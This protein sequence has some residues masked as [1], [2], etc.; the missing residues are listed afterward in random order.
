MS[1]LQLGLQVGSNQALTDFHLD[2]LSE[3]CAVDNSTINIALVLLLPFIILIEISHL[4]YQTRAYFYA[5][6]YT[7]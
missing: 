7:I 4:L 1:S 6:L 5:Q 2:D 3:L